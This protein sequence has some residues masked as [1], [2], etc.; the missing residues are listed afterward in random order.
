M[1]KA[2]KD[3]LL[4]TETEVCGYTIKQ[5]SFGELSKITPD[6]VDIFD[7]VVD[8]VE[9]LGVRFGQD[10][11]QVVKLILVLLPDFTPIIAK[12]CAV[13]EQEIADLPGPDGVKLAAAIWQLNQGMFIDFFDIAGS[14]VLRN[15]E[16]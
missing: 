13:E 15:L 12:I 1:S 8:T 6:L 11:R 4:F 10:A 3:E 14:P 7:K 16:P 2:N 9:T 5:L